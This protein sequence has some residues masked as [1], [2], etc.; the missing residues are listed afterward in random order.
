[1]NQTTTTTAQSDMIHAGARHTM[2][3]AQSQRDRYWLFLCPKI[4]VLGLDAV[5]RKDIG[6][7]CYGLLTSSPFTDH[8]KSV[9]GLSVQQGT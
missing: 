7:A 4:L 1:M 5:I 6:P 9:S 2:K 3:Q 8:C